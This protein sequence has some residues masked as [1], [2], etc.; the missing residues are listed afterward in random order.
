MKTQFYII[1]FIFFV[2]L[3]FL[4]AQNKYDFIP[5]NYTQ[6]SEEQVNSGQI[7]IGPDVLLFSSKGQLLSKSQMVLMANPE[8]KPIFFADEKGK[9]KALV[10]ER[11]TDNPIL[12][13]HNPESYFEK[14][15][16]AKDFIVTDLE[17]NHI[18]LSELRGKVVALNF[19]FIKCKPCIMEMPY[20][21]EL[22]SLYKSKNVIF[23]AITF[24]SAELVQQF[25]D[26]H[27]FNYTIAAKASDAIDIFGVNS[28][29]TN[30][31]INQKGEIVLKELGFRTNI[32]DV[33]RA[34]IDELLR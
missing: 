2:S 10:F 4:Q 33:L 22:K 29:P 27:E 21:N 25:L 24:D 1:A 6:L 19:W 18:K 15:E 5:I 8:Y 9:I 32:K 7:M 31:V 20:L 14:G 30:I 13:D 3:Q 11:V 26:D 28:Y 17:G 12:I 23:L 16:M 34:S